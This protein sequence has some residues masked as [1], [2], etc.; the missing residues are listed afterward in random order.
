MVPGRGYLKWL[1]ETSAW[2]IERLG[3]TQA[4]RSRARLIT[5]TYEDFPIDRA[6]E[7]DELIEDF[8]LFVLEHAGLSRWPFELSP[9]DHRG[10][11]LIHAADENLKTMLVPYERGMTDAT[12]IVG[13]LSRGVAYHLVRQAEIVDPHHEA[14]DLATELATVILGFGIFSAN[15]SGR[16]GFAGL[17][18]AD[19]ALSEVET[20]Y[21]LALYAIL[22][23]QP[24]A[25]ILP[26]LRVNPHGF[27]RAACRELLRNYGPELRRLRQVTP[28]P[29][30][31]RAALFEAR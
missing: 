12:R 13:T 28:T 1:F 20:S 23:E 9:D 2:L 29:Y 4:L 24:D 30:R 3:G 6:L 18:L 25:R 31:S 10:P 22:F 15:T 26:Y 21:A 16:R 19:T 17:W 5:P 8:F 11:S 14:F 7:H 27:Y